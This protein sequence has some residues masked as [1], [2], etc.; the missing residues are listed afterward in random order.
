MRTVEATTLNER[1]FT[2]MPQDVFLRD[3]IGKEDILIVSI[4]G[5]DIALRPTICTIASMAGLLCLP[6]SF[7]ENGCSCCAP[8]VSHCKYIVHASTMPLSLTLNRV[9]C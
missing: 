1:C 5:N 7:V 8:S 3:H 9:W 4:G 2:L 6:V